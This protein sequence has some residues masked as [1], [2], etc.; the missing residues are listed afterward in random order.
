MFDG[1]SIPAEL[2]QRIVLYES[3]QSGS[4]N[5]QKKSPEKHAPI[6]RPQKFSKIP[7]KTRLPLQEVG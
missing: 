2:V 5:S 1:D 4:L 3:P 7:V 6:S